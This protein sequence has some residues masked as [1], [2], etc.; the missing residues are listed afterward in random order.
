MEVLFPDLRLAARTLIK[1]PG[2]T[3]VA[4]VTLALGVGVNTA[5]FSVVN[6]TSLR[7]SGCCLAQPRSCC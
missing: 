5:V 6:G 3:L 2:F 1:H 7:R 4:V